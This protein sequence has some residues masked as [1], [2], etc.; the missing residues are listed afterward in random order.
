MLSTLLRL[1]LRLLLPLLCALRCLLLPLRLLL[2]LWRPLL[3]LGLCLLPVSLQLPPALL[4]FLLFVVA[5][6]VSGYD[7]SGKQT[8]R[9]GAGSTREFHVN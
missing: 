3:L 1:C 2:D 4:L 5:L 9:S 8:N 7:Q 6:R